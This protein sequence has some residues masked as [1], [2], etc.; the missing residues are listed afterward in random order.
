HDYVALIGRA[1][2]V[3]LIDFPALRVED[4]KNALIARDAD[5][6]QS[7]DRNTP[8][9][10]R[11]TLADG[12]QEDWAPSYLSADL[13][14]TEFGSLLNFADGILK[15]QSLSDTIRYRGYDIKTFP[16]PPYEEGVFKHL[17]ESTGLSS[18]IFNFNTVG[19]GHWLESAEG[20][21]TYA[22]NS[23]GSFSVTYSPDSTGSNSTSEGAASVARA[24]ADYT[25]WF[26]QQ[27]SFEL[28]RTVQY[29][30]I[31]QIFC[32]LKVGGARLY[33]SGEEKF[34][35]LG[36]QLRRAV[37]QGAGAALTL[38]DGSDEDKLKEL[39]GVRQMILL[40]QGGVADEVPPMPATIEE[41]ISKLA[42]AATAV[43][44][45]GNL[46]GDRYQALIQRHG[47]LV[48]Q[49]NTV[50]EPILP[51]LSR[52]QRLRDEFDRDFG[53]YQTGKEPVYEDGELVPGA[54]ITKYQV[55][56]SLSSSFERDKARLKS[57]EDVLS[58]STE[59]LYRLRK[60]IEEAEEEVEELA[61]VFVNHGL[62]LEAL[63]LVTRME[64]PTMVLKD[65]VARSVEVGLPA[66]AF[67]ISTPSIVVSV[68]KTDLVGAVTG[69]HDI[70]VRRF[71]V[72]LDNGVPKGSFRLN[73]GVLR[74]SPDDAPRITD[75]SARMAKVVD[76][77]P[78]TQR[79]VF[80]AVTPPT[81]PRSR[82]QALSLSAD[83]LKRLESSSWRATSVPD[84][85]SFATDTSMVLG[86]DAKT[87]R[88]FAE[89]LDQAGE[90]QRTA[91]LGSTNSPE[92]IDYFA[93]QKGDPA[94]VEVLLDPSL[95]RGDVDA[96]VANYKS[97]RPQVASGLGGGGGGPPPRRWFK[98]PEPEP[99]SLRMV[100]FRQA[101]VG[102]QR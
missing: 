52:Y 30:A 72:K 51:E 62:L 94:V 83:S 10:G 17:Q 6:A 65:L 74:L 14:D 8:G 1:R 32:D 5:W 38:L 48:D 13:I 99:Q 58:P 88:L 12:E 35:A 68:D 33:P 86:R 59:Y 47:T 89:R 101:G 82:A 34:Q 43:R 79:R 64:F 56:D 22:L 76:A 46:Y 67:A 81:P 21:R 19:V 71:T 70:A 84:T 54:F 11:A 57:I 27:R 85:K 16:D 45:D 77:D 40:F 75:L 20:R 90:V 100:I 29:M 95:A 9:A 87:G 80:E 61:D 60:A 53:A 23:T 55:P 3:P 42:V 93:K 44:Y 66:G 18:L 92:F 28:V 2:Q 26:R 36:N 7:Y 98:M 63:A 97:A 73:D 24:E 25:D 49:H 15:S 4:I 31:Y 37:S 50:L 69:G 78:F 96:I 41:L 39:D 102:R 91:L